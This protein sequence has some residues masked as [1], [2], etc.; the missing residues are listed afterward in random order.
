MESAEQILKRLG[1]RNQFDALITQIIQALPP[2]KNNLAQV[3]ESYRSIPH[4]LVP[5]LLAGSDCI[6]ALRDTLQLGLPINTAI[7]TGVLAG[8]TRLFF[9]ISNGHLNSVRLFRQAGCAFGVSIALE[10][11]CTLNYL[12]VAARDNHLVLLPEIVSYLRA[13]GLLEQKLHEVI[14]PAKNDTPAMNT[15]QACSRYFTGQH[16]NLD[17]FCKRLPA[18]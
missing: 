8:T 13:D 5:Y 14:L 6:D 7:P 17:R 15:Y 11:N 12:Y 10:Q 3:Y 9:A 4:I 16:S 18:R 2:A 1:L